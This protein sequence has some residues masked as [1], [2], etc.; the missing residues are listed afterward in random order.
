M[1]SDIVLEGMREGWRAI[2]SAG[3]DPVLI[4][5]IAIQKHGRIRQTKDADFL[6]LIEEADFERIFREAEAIGL[7]RHPTRPV[8]R[9]EHDIILRL[10]Y[11]DPKFGIEVRID[12]I[13]AGDRFSRE[14][15]ARARA[16]EV[17]GISLRL[18]TCEDLILLKLLAGRPVD[19]ADAIDLIGFN[20]DRLEWSYLR[21]RARDLK[22][23][24]D[25]A[26]AE[27]ESQ[28]EPT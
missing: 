23:D 18:A 26:D 6:A 10:I 28:E 20:R 22:L 9:L 4:G 17:F 1:V 11:E 14:V 16:T 24:S 2:R 5:G 15:V 12:V 25:L 19:R 8:L 3:F 21:G 13:R 7:R 27:R